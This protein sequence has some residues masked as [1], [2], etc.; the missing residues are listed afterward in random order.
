MVIILY[1]GVFNDKGGIHTETDGIAI[2]VEV[3]AQAFEFKTNDEINNMSSKFHR[4]SPLEFRSWDGSWIRIQKQS[5]SYY[6]VV[7]SETGQF[8]IES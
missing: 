7:G 3:R 5:G 8:Q 6:L 1:S 4:I 2:G